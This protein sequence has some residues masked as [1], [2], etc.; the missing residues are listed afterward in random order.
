MHFFHQTPAIVRRLV[1][2][3]PTIAMLEGV[4]VV[5]TT[6]TRIGEV[7]EDF[8]RVTSAAGRSTER[9]P[10]I[11]SQTYSLSGLTREPW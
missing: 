9:L 7:H 6:L 8:L 4:K 3:T 11:D 1:G 5:E 2:L 10:H